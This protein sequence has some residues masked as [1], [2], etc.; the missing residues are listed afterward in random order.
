MHDVPGDVD[1]RPGRRTT[2]GVGHRLDVD[3]RLRW[4][5]RAEKAHGQGKRDDGRDD[6]QLFHALQ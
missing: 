6:D 4:P 5:R 2:Y 1:D 3:D